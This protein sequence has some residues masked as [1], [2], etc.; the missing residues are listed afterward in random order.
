MSWKFII[1][2]DFPIISQWKPQNLHFLTGFYWWILLILEFSGYP[3][4]SPMLWWL[5]P[6][7]DPLRYAEKYAAD[8]NAFFED[9]KATTRFLRRWGKYLRF[10]GYAVFPR[11]KHQKKIW[12]N[13]RIR[14]SVRF[15]LTIKQWDLTNLGAWKW[16]T[17]Y[18]NFLAIK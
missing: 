2:V 16:G 12:S 4:G 5:F 14:L 3:P 18:F 7:D 6:R 1:W 13:M 17:V 8:Q 15:Y 9:Y 10:K 11:E